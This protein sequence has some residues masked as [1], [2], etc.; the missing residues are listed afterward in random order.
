MKRLLFIL[1]LFSAVST[2]AN[3]FGGDSAEQSQSG[4]VRTAL[5]EYDYNSSSLFEHY[6]PSASWIGIMSRK[7][8]CHVVLKALVEYD[9]ENPASARILGA[10]INYRWPK[11][12]VLETYRLGDG[13]YRDVKEP[14]GYQRP[15]THELTAKIYP[16]KDGTFV[17]TFKNVPNA[18]A[19]FLEVPGLH[20]SASFQS[21]EPV[22][23]A[24]LW[25]DSLKRRFSKLVK[26]KNSRIETEKRKSEPRI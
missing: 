13:S 23:G 12:V 22:S 1:S 7:A 20:V 18:N 24:D 17:I 3:D 10:S 5:V 4:A 26:K 25:I 6:Y 21:S 14:S 11:F 8:Y 19:E 15:I 9:P 16:K 2:Y